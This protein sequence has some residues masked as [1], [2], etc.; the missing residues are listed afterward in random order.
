MY[1]FTHN[2]VMINAI[3]ISVWGK[4]TKKSVRTHHKTQLVFNYIGIVD[5]VV[6]LTSIRHACAALN[7]TYLC[8]TSTSMSRS[9]ETLQKIPHWPGHCRQYKGH[10]ESVKDRRLTVQGRGVDWAGER[11][12]EGWFHSGAKMPRPRILT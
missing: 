10:D 5:Y 11:N 12:P 2:T 1:T 8:R 6:I 9:S 7:L 4:N 3:L